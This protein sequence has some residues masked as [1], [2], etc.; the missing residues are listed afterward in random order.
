MNHEEWKRREERQEIW[1]TAF[2]LILK[3]QKCEDSNFVGRVVAA[4]NIVDEWELP[5]YEE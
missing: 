2:S 3:L 5:R 4:V 1:E